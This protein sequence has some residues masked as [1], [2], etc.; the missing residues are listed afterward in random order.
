MALLLLLGCFLPARLPAAPG[1]PPPLVLRGTLVVREPAGYAIVED[2]RSGQQREY[3]TGEPILPGLRLVAVHPDHALLQR[4]R[5]RFR[6]EFGAPISRS[7][8]RSAR[9]YRIPADRIPDILAG[10]ELL[11]HQQEGKPVGY[12]VNRLAP[13]LQ[14]WLG[15]RT[16]D[17]ITRVAGREVT[18]LGEGD[19]AGLL[20]RGRAR[21]EVLRQGQRL[22]F[23]YRLAKTARRPRLKPGPARPSPTTASP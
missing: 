12:Y 9:S 7:T 5:E 15:L 8:P 22:Q 19:L 4:G 6:V 2:P 23:D 14:P 20:A 10:V 11:P 13:P 16:G 18:K 21:L 3:H 1:D 17:I